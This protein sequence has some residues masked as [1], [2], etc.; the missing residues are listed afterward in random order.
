MVVSGETVAILI[1]GLT[2]AVALVRVASAFTALTVKVERLE[3]ALESLQSVV[4]RIARVEE[5]IA[6]MNDERD[7]VS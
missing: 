2:L 4:E 5:R 6:G 7:T 1:G 3:R